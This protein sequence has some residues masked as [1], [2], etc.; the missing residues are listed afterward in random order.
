MNTKILEETQ[1]KLFSRKEI[2]MEIEHSAGS[3]PNRKELYEYLSAKFK[4]PAS[5]I[6]LKKLNS[7]FGLN[8]SQAMA[9]IYDN[10]EIIPKIENKHM[11]KR[12]E[13][14]LKVEEKPVESQ[15]KEEPAVEA[16]SEAEKVDEEETPKEQPVEEKNAE[17][18]EEQPVETEAKEE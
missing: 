1:N 10:T 2:S 16:P 5:Q 14:A 12:R 3:T 6:I 4:K 8:K 17:N 7:T 18:L 13:N 11:L 15:T 9:Y